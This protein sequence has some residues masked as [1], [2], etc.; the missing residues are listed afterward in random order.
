MAT[1]LFDDVY[2][3]LEKLFLILYLLLSF[4]L[5]IIHWLKKE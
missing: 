3:P 2:Y 4:A 1:S 5:A